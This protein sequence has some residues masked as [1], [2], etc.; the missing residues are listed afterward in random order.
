MPRD[1]DD[2]GGSGA[3]R[4]AQKAAS[5]DDD[6]DDDFL[7]RRAPSD[8]AAYKLIEHFRTSEPHRLMLIRLREGWMVSFL[9]DF[10]AALR[11]KP[12]VAQ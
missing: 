1:E 7:E 9:T 8:A 2:A 5:N 6:C 12:L 11:S 10:F 4:V 3:P